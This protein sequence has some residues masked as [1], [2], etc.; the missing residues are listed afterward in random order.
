MSKK[1]DPLIG[2][3]KYFN[4]VDLAAADL[5]LIMVR[6]IVHSRQPRLAASKPA[7]AA[8]AAASKRR[9]EQE[10]PLPLSSAN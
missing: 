3:I 7:K 9:T 5:A 6:E 2:V 1:K 8:P 4:T 10:P